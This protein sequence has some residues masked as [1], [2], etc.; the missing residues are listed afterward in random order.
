MAEIDP[1][2][3]TDRYVALWNEPDADLRRTAVRE[4]WAEN[5]SHV[6]QA[7]LDV[8]RTAG[9][10][11]FGSAVFEARGHVELERRVSLA[12]Q[13]FVAP[14]TFTFRSRGNADRLHDVVKF[15]WEMVSP[16]GD[17]GGV[18][19]EVL[20]LDPDGLIHRDYQ[21]IESRP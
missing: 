7:P 19:L 4:L 10:L 20:L 3:L 11:G 21:F 17:L 1:Q 13:E 6:L 9:E 15:T 8:R 14:G 18:G 12:H 5:G 2:V 16:N